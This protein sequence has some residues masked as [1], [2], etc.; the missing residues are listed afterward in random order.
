MIPVP[1]AV[2]AVPTWKRLPHNQGYELRWTNDDVAILK[3]P[4]TFSSSL[5]ATSSHRTWTFRRVGLL[6]A[7][8]EIID[9]FSQQRIATYKSGW[10]GSGTLAFAD[11]QS[12]HF[13]C[14]GVWHPTWTITA[15]QGR[16]VLWL[17]SR[18]KTIEVAPD[19]AFPDTR[20]FLLAIFALYRVLTAEEDAS[21]AA[22][23]A[24]A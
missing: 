2:S 24:V 23:I 19:V 10:G 18:E 1:L 16:V 3:H 9:S 7:S 21:S 12:F 11:G 6:G 15:S 8:A 14:K 13:D 5:L 20:L 22:M 4:S 17:H